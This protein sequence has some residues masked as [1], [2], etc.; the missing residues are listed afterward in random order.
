MRGHHL[1]PE[2]K[3]KSD[4]YAW[5]LE[6]FFAL[7]LTD[8]LAQSAIL[9]YADITLDQELAYDLRRAVKVARGE[10]PRSAGEGTA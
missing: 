9:Y 7:K 10:P 2:G 4:K 3:F 6:G 1:T 5:C 8:V